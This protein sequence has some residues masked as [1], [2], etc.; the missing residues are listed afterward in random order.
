MFIEANKKCDKAKSL[1][2]RLFNV[3]IRKVGRLWIC[4]TCLEYALF[5]GDLYRHCLIR[6]LQFRPIDKRILDLNE[7]EERLCSPRLPF[8]RIKPLKWDRQKGL[9][10]NVVNVP[11]DVN[12]IVKMLP[13]AF[14][15]SET[16]QLNI[17]ARTLLVSV[18]DRH[19]R[20]NE[21]CSCIGLFAQFRIV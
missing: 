17:K 11:V 14:A 20:P 13:R 6:N 21:D 15:D 7:T 19:S 5:N 10:G 16:V 2:E 9:R 4:I 3:T 1:T 18:H 8:L 12:D